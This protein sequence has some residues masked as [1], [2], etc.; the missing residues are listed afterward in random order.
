M[1]QRILITDDDV[2]IQG[3]LRTRLDSL[4]YE[5]RLECNAADLRVALKEEDFQ[6]LLL[7]INLPDGDGIDLISEVHEIDPDLPII[8]ITAHGS[9]EK[10]VEAMRR[11]AYDFCTK[12]IDFTRLP[13]SVKNAAERKALTR[14]IVTLERSQKRGLCD[15]IGSSPEMQVIYRI[16]ETVAPSKAP[17]LITGESGTGKE[18]GGGCE[19]YPSSFTP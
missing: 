9:I 11:G 5:T 18:L 1:K 19:S 15:L 13:V 10:A 6:V 12:P 2:D 16:I 8:M 14:R 3:L 17:V 7:D 4:G